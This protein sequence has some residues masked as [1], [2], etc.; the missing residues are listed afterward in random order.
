MKFFEFCQEREAIRK[1]RAV[2]QLPPWTADERLATFRFTNID[3]RHDKGTVVMVNA[4]KASEICRASYESVMH[5]IAQYR[6]L[7]S[8]LWYPEVCVNLTPPE[9]NSTIVERWHSGLPVMSM[10]AY[11]LNVPKG[12]SGITLSTLLWPTLPT[13]IRK[14]PAQTGMLS[15]RAV[16]GQYTKDIGYNS[17]WFHGMEIAK[18]IALVFPSL[19][20]PQS[21]VALGPG[22]IAGAELCREFDESTDDVLYRLQN[23]SLSTNMPMTLS[24]VEHALCEYNK[25][26]AGTKRRYDYILE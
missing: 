18:D 3:R 8:P 21:P 4:I 22:A 14:L 12:M 24:T 16:V 20:D 23:Q 6:I 17:C 10:R 11:Q 7:G 1:R 25:Y 26:C 15:V 5:F 2:G 13:K 9:C 19:V